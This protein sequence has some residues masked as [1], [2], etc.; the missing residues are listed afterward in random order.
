[1]GE[2]HVNMYSTL[3]GVIES[4]GGP[5]EESDSDF[6]YGGWQAA[7]WDQESE[8]QV[9][10]DVKESDALLLGRKTYDIFRRAWPNATDE[11]GE[12]FNR[13]PKYVVSRGAP[14]LSWSGTTVIPDVTEV[15]AL[16][17][18]HRAVHTWG[19]ANLLQDLLRARLVDRI[20]LWVYPVLLGQGQKLFPD[21]TVP[22]NLQLI[23]PPT[24]FPGGAVLSRYTVA[25]RGTVGGDMT[26]RD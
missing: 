15:A 25:D 26:V 18:K 21:G 20:N 16:R 9:I 8:R 3:D 6:A 19:S 11:I 4:N 22:T 1:M 12:V 10:T 7:F 17:E 23:E 13:V 2:L 5:D 24:A 14:E